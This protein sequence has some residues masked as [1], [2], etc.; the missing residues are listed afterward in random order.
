MA[1]EPAPQRA[2][3]AACPNCGAPVEFRSAASA[4]EVCS[5]CRSQVVRDGEALRRIGQSAELFDDHTVLRLGAAGRYQGAPFTLVGRLQ[6]GYADGTWNEWH[7]LFGGAGDGTG[8]GTGAGRSGWLSEDN[9]RHVF[10]FDAPVAAGAD[11]PPASAL[12][13]GAAVAFAGQPWSVASVTTARVLAA[14][15]ELPRPPEPVDAGFVVAEL[16]SRRNEVAT[17]EYVNA[18][19]PRASIGRPVTLR[20]LAL[21]GLVDTA[22][23][24]T[25]AGRSLACPNCGAAL[26]VRLATTR[27]IVCGRCKS[28]VDLGG[29]AGQGLGGAFA[30]YRQENGREPQ[31]PLGSVGTLALG[32]PQ[33]PWQVVGYV[34]RHEVGGDA[35]AADDD[36]DHTEPAAQSFWREYLL[37]QRT[38]GFAFL[39]DAEDGWSWTVPV[40]GVP[41]QRDAEG[42]VVAWQGASYRRLYAYTGQVSYVLG[43]FYWRLT[44]AQ[45]TANVDYRGVGTAAARR[46]NRE[47][48]VGA[49]GDAEVVW[50]AGETL[51]AEAV[52]AA[53]RLPAGEAAALQRDALPTSLGGG[54]TAKVFIGLLVLGLLFMLVRCDAGGSGDSGDSGGRDCES[55]R[56][57]FGASS[58]EY[59]N[60]IASGRSGGGFGTAGGAFG[61]YSSGGGHK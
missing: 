5:F 43:E 15:G 50:S 17:L 19:A 40:T 47:Q 27:A 49:G 3:R 42:A 48:T 30:H 24:K 1:T 59:Q 8:D 52:R 61:G 37:Y 16:R 28:V 26:E 11:L 6:L 29:P 38:T 4:I 20:E 9:G 45:R 46:L 31:I 56:Q 32:G 10:A 13:V 23:E 54:W 12:R 18:Q 53:F 60:C 34:E 33:Q 2:Y 57:T 7:A 25:L 41:E 22:P 21:T 58:A 55:L 51:P 35:D 39:V 36:A 14:E 44:Q